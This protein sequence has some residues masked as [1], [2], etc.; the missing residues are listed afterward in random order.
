MQSRFMPYDISIPF[1][2]SDAKRYRRHA[3]KSQSFAEPKDETGFL[4]PLSGDIY[5][6][7]KVFEMAED[8]ER[9]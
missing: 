9:Q 7:H 4:K 2:L 3:V 8:G 5:A 6:V 1:T